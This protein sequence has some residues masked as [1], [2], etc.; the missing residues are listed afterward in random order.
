MVSEP[1]PHLCSAALCRRWGCTATESR[2]AGLLA[3][4]LDLRDAAQQMG[5]T[6]GKA[7][8][9]LKIVFDKVGV[10]TQSQFVARLFGGS[11]DSR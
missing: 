9:Y 4:G 10:D 1:A 8:G 3:A 5:V 7:I 11:A 2:L 6:Y